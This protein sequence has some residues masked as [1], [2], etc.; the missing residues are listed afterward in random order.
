MQEVTIKQGFIAAGV[1]NIGGVLL[2]SRGLSNETLK[3]IDPVIL[4]NFG[5]VMILVWGLAYISVAGIH[6][7][8]RWLTGVFAIEKL[9]YGTVWAMWMSENTGQMASIY[10]QDVF[11]GIFYTIY[12]VNDLIFAIFFGWVFWNTRRLAPNN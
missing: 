8:V 5:L 4:G 7:Q 1:M 10:A 11:A 6:G 3:Q 2:F 12:G 9:I